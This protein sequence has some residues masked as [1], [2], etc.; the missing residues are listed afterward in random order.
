MNLIRIDH[1]SLDVHDRS[2][3]IDWYEDVIGVRASGAPGPVDQPV[4]LGPPGAQL[5]LFAERAPS[6]RH[7]ALATDAAGFDATLARL[8]ERAILFRVERHGA[9]RSVYFDDPDGTTLEVTT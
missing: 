2:R 5:G 6:L 7:I 4:F 8:S 9:R 1:V 3:S